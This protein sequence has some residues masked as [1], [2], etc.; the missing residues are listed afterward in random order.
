M[1]NTWNGSYHS[2]SQCVCGTIPTV[3]VAGATP[4]VA[5]RATATL[6]GPRSRGPA[7]RTGPATAAAPVGGSRRT[8]PAMPGAPDVDLARTSVFLDFDGTVTRHD[9]GRHLLERFADD[10]WRRL[11][12]EYRAGRIGSRECVLGQWELLEA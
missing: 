10:E 3:V 9:V 2:R 11:S 1:R 7:E 5:L 4:P 8:M 6:L 12:D